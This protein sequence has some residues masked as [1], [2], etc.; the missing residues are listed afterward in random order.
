MTNTNNDIKGDL[1]YNNSSFYL[2]LIFIPSLPY[3][4]AGILM[5]N[6]IYLSWGIIMVSIIYTF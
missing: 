2:L 3:I 6:L 5:G 1:N 4:L